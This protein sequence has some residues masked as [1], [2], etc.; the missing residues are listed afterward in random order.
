MERLYNTVPSKSQASELPVKFTIDG[1]SDNSVS[2]NPFA[3]SE[4]TSRPK[5]PFEDF[6]SSIAETLITNSEDRFSED[7]TSASTLATTGRELFEVIEEQPITEHTVESFDMHVSSSTAPV[8]QPTVTSSGNAPI[9]HSASSPGYLF[10]GGTTSIFNPVS[11]GT[12]TSD[13][14]T[15]QVRTHI[16]PIAQN[17]RHQPIM[18]RHLT[19]STSVLRPIPQEGTFS[20]DSIANHTNPFY[21]GSVN[22]GDYP[23]LIPLPQKPSGPR[24]PSYV[25][26]FPLPGNKT[27]SHSP[28]QRRSGKPPLKPQPYTGDCP[29]NHQTNGNNSNT[30]DAGVV[31]QRRHSS[32]PF[33][34]QRLPSIG[35]F[36]P[37]GDLLN[38]G[39]SGGYV[40]QNSNALK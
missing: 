10:S 19:L 21:S 37:F 14:S 2:T 28:S 16:N 4:S 33:Q 1:P 24:S 35:D 6:S 30:T 25:Q 27:G 22:A 36:D 13:I 20:A 34:P 17:P 9:F 26:N 39:G 7:P 32:A 40:L 15:A 5:S 31:L 38:N 12:P 29:W 11:A 23:A 18:N 8:L 3:A